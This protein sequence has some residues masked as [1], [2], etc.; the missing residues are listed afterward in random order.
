MAESYLHRLLRLY[1]ANIDR[2]VV[3]SRYVMESWCNG[4]WRASASS[5]SRTSSTPGVQAGQMRR[6]AFRLLRPPRRAQ[7]RRNAGAGRGAARQPLTLV[8]AGPMDAALRA[9][10]AD[11]RRRRDIYRS[12]DQGCAGRGDPAGPRGRR[13]VGVQENAPLAV[14][15]AYAAGRPVIGA[16][17]AGIPELVR[18]EETGMLY[19]TRRGC[20]A[21]GGARRDLRNLPDARVAAMGAAGRAWGSG[22]SMPAA[23]STASLRSTT[24]PRRMSHE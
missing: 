4:V 12:S 6:P 5:I 14:L 9:V 11:A 15:E 8:G 17:I 13:A 1:D 23:I 18:E 19:P 7:R 2:F 16:R 24:P 3:P 20:S 10:G 21:R 22:I